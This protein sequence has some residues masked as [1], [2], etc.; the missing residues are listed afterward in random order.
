[1]NELDKLLDLA[2]ELAAELEDMI[3]ETDELLDS[4]DSPTRVY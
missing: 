2:D 1:M 3:R 4:I